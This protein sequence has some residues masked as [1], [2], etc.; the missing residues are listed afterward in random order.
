MMKYVCK[1]GLAR[2]VVGP[3]EF[4]GNRRWS[5]GELVE[6]HVDVMTKAD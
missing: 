5:T 6:V 3:R 2:G 1:E 4:K